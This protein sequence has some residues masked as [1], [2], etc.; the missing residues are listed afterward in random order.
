MRSAKCGVRSAGK[1]KVRATVTAADKRQVAAYVADVA[2]KYP[3]RRIE[4]YVA[5]IVG[6]RAYALRRVGA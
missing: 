4:A 6:N 3:G 5:A 2:V 1:T